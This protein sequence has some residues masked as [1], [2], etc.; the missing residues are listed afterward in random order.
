MRTLIMR[1][2]SVLFAIGLSVSAHLSACAHS[3]PDLAGS[4]WRPQK[5]DSVDVPGEPEM[6]VRFGEGGR[7]EGHGG[8]NRFFG[9]YTLSS[10]KVAIG[11]IGATRM[12]CQEP[13]M[14]RET[15]FLRALESARRFKR[16]RIDLRMTG[17]EGNAVIR[18]I[19]RDAD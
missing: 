15:S 9:S 10:G 2:T 13:V 7:L 16:D 12:A 11:P 6:F 14:D 19:Q 5:I 1:R 4:E 3:G 18:L 8:C 17:D